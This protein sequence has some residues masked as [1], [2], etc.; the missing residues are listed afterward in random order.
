[1][2]LAERKAIKEFETNNYP[3]L[4]KRVVDAAGYNLEIEVKWEELE[5]PDTPTSNYEY[6]FTSIYFEPLIEALKKIAV[7]DMGKSA[8]KEGLKK[9]ILRDTSDNFDL[10]VFTFED[11]V[12]N[13]DFGSHLNASDIESKVDA[14]QQLLESKL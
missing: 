3:D 2:G 13:I 7:D 8:L 12:L 11:G 6:N 1:M 10:S 14:I 5:T 4:A 9:V